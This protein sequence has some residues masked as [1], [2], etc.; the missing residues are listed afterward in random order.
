MKPLIDNFSTGSNDYA[1]FRPE[2]PVEV[3]DFLYNAVPGFNSAWDCGTGNGQVAVQLAGKFE[4]VY[5][6]DISTEQ[7]QLAQKR[8]N[9]H[10]LKERAEQTS[11]A[12]DSIDLTTVAQAIHWFDFEK[13]YHEVTRVSMQGALFAAW[14]YSTLKMSDAV[15]EVID[16]LYTDIT[17]PYWDKE[18]AYVDAGYSTIPFV[19]DEIETPDFGILKHWNIHQVAG[20]LRTW[21]GVKHYVKKENHDPVL[22]IWND[23]EKA[24]GS[25]ELIEVRWPVHMRAGFVKK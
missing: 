9:I 24:W 5:G 3:F 18:R 17:G 21:S 16:R 2:S 23:L 10:Y 20:Y 11:L 22:L 1:A 13:F 25:N 19:F 15:N 6:T 7:M 8:D 14:T 12:D 4:T